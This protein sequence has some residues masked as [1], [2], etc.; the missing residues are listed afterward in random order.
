MRD[1]DFVDEQRN[2]DLLDAMADTFADQQ[3]AMRESTPQEWIG[4]TPELSAA[5]VND[6][7]RYNERYD[8]P[9]SD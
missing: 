9:L 3:E 4:Y 1:P 8:C 5:E 2:A 6:Y 7:R